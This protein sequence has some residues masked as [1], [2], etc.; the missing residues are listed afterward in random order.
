MLVTTSYSELSLVAARILSISDWYSS[1]SDEE[2]DEIRSFTLR[3]VEVGFG[4]FLLLFVVA[5]VVE[6]V[7]AV[8]VFLLEITLVEVEVELVGVGVGASESSSVSVVLDSCVGPWNHDAAPLISFPVMSCLLSIVAYA[9]S[10]LE[11]IPTGETPEPPRARGRRPE[12]KSCL[13][14]LRGRPSSLRAAP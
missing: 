10:R 13:R 2:N 12:T 1:F 5:A 4:H 3:F 14:R 7:D 6:L 9:L 8:V 11:N